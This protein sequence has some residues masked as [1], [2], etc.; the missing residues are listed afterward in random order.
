[1]PDNSPFLDIFL[2][3]PASSLISYCRLLHYGVVLLVP[4]EANVAE[5]LRH[6]LQLNEEDLDFVQTVFLDCSPL[7]DLEH[8]RPR[9][10]SVL[11]ISAALP[12]LVG[13][14]MRR[15]GALARL[16][17]SINLREERN[18]ASPQRASI[19]RIELTLKI[20]NLLQ[21]RLGPRLLAQGVRVNAQQLAAFL[22]GLG[23]LGQAS[24][25]RVNGNDADPEALLSALSATSQPALLR[26][27]PT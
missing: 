17:E 19:E 12:G 4:A 5:I 6:G 2:K 26:V 27:L 13:A 8:A 11:A 10:G 21:D 1:M 3:V 7:D 25:L 15:S 16:R 20:F 18:Q 23:L 14:V 9:S 22:Q 24:A